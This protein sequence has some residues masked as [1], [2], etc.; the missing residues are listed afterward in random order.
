LK[1]KLKKLIKKNLNKLGLICQNCNLD[2]LI[3]IT[4]HKTKQIETDQEGQLPINEIFN[5]KIKIYIY[6]YIYQLKK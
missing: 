2:H 5:D 6:I 3:K 4:P 1:K